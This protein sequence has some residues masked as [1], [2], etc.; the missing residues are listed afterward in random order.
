MLISKMNPDELTR[1]Q[2]TKVVFGGRKDADNGSLRG[3]CIFVF[4]SSTLSRA[5]KG[6]ELFLS[7]RA[8][9]LLFS[10]G[11]RFGQKSKPEA[12]LYRDEAIKRGVP[13]KF[14]LTETVSN[15]TKE[16]V[17]CSLTVLD[18]GIG[19]ENINRLLLVSAPFH[20]RRCLLMLRTFMPPWYEYTWCPDER[21]SCQADNWWKT[22][23]G[24]QNVQAELRKVIGG[25]RGKYFVDGEVDFDC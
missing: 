15:H 7:G 4:G 10:G 17:M 23:T 16:N 9:Y 14:I 13:G 5:V 1:D 20:M 25:V 24:M 11:D 8:P 18:R 19:L 22:E 6:T 12:E 21:A 2:I 3:D